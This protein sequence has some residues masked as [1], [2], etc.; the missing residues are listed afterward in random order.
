VHSVRSRLTAWNGGL[1]TVILLISGVAAYA[2]LKHAAIEQVDQ[3]VHQQL[4][5]VTL[6]LSTPRPADNHR[7]ALASLVNELRN[8]G[9]KV[10]AS[11]TPAVIMTRALR[12]GHGETELRERTPNDSTNQDLFE[13]ALLSALLSRAGLINANVR[14]APFTS[15]SANGGVR[16]VL[17]DTT[18]N[19]FP[20]TL[21]ASEPLNEVEELLGEARLMLI[22]AIPI[23]ASIALL[24]GYWQARNALAPVSAMTAQ[25]GR[26]GARN[27]HERLAVANPHDELGQLAT[28]FNSV[29]ERVDRA[30]HQQHQF[31]AD[32][33]HELRTPLAIIRSEADVTLDAGDRSAQEYR[34]SL[35]VIRDGSEQ[36]SRIVNDL[37]LLARADAGETLP[38]RIA[39]YLDDLVGDAVRSVRALAATRNIELSLSTPDSA[40]Y[41]GDEQ[42]LRRVLINLLDNA[43]KYSPA[44]S[45]IAVTLEQ[46]QGGFRIAVADS[47]P[48]IS[49]EAK[50]F[51]FDRFYRVSE[52]RGSDLTAHGSGAGL[53]LAIARE[54]VELHGGTLTLRD[55]EGQARVG[56]TFEIW[57]PAAR[58]E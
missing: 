22:V 9:Y 11:E 19:G 24:V 8:R 15:E 5:A 33:S 3:A 32:A 21:A 46:L 50:P 26:M 4:R 16:V 34:E 1:I 14:E 37:F 40:S 25:A 48:G 36:L 57:L 23:V 47:G 28:T 54:I 51:V 52:T 29:L 31:T 30:M 38:R 7:T 20:L 41:K 58:N 39:I 6:T 18:F 10:T 53:G 49:V 44:Y 35:S 17:K 12:S 43:I 55:I 56:S 42:L 13:P 45:T 2:L 27:L